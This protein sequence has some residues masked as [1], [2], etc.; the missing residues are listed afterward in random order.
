M[1][2]G[3]SAAETGLGDQCGEHPVNQD[4]EQDSSRRYWKAVISALTTAEKRDAAWEFYL[5]KFAGCNARDTLSGL[6]L[7]LEADSI[8][9][10][11]SNSPHK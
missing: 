11:T 6:I 5:Y 8:L 3:K 9:R 2:N 4:E 10:A 1:R 7:L